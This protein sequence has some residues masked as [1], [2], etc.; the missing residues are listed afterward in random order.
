MN[1]SETSSKI[2]VYIGSDHAGYDMKQKIISD[3]RLSFINFI[4][5]G[6][7]SNDSVDYPDYAEILANNVLKNNG[8]GVAICGTGIGISIALNKVKG[9]YTAVIN[10]P[11]IA[12]L[13]REHNN[14]NVVSLSG[15]F[16]TA[17]NNIKI[18]ENFFKE[19]FSNDPRHLKRLNKIKDI[20][21]K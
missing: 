15:R 6:T 18:I 2:N 8:Y 20:E 17:D 14:L 13:A 7:N 21:K 3:P 9:I 12:K 11:E 19:N 4:D 16:S 1:K 5:V 10:D